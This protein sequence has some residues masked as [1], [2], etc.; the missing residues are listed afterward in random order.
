MQRRSA[1]D[2]RS[3]KFN[4]QMEIFAAQIAIDR[5]RLI[6]LQSISSPIARNFGTYEAEREHLAAVPVTSAT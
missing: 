1:Q 6:R 3:S 4:S 2:V 5:I